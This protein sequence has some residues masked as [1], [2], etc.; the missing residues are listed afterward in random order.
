MNLMWMDFLIGSICSRNG[1]NIRHSRM[2]DDR[3]DTQPKRTLQS[4]DRAPSYP[5]T[6]QISTPRI[7]HL[8]AV[9]KETFRYH[10]P[11][12]FIARQKDGDD[13]EIGGYVIPGN[14]VVLINIWAI[15]GDPRIWGNPEEFEPERFLDGDIDVKGQD[16]ELIPFGAGRR[17]C[18]GQ[19]LAHRMVH[20]MVAA[21][22]HNFDWEVENG[23]REVDVSEKFGLS[24]QKALPLKVVPIKLYD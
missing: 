19:A 17:I 8:Q 18:P 13:V 11:G 9:I 14:A 2:G 7:R 6:E 15:G 12:P 1:H 22:I 3:T 4:Q 16:F 24:L 20:V 23:M 21:L 5:R 10:P